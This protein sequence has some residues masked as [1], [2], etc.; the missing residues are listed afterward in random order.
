MERVRAAL[1]GYNAT[2]AIKAALAAME[3][4]E[5]WRRC[6]PPLSPVPDTIDAALRRALTESSPGES[7]TA[8]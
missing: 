1:A 4:D 3:G 6:R 7:A 8:P 2:A 5:D